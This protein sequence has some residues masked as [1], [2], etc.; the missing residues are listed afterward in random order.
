MW[1]FEVVSPHVCCCK[2]LL[3]AVLA[4]HK[5]GDLLSKTPLRQPS[6][7][8]QSRT[9]YEDEARCIRLSAWT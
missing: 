6:L 9:C 3:Q 5:A 4:V 1:Q 2:R 7:F 8:A